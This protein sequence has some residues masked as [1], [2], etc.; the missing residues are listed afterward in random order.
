MGSSLVA[1]ALLSLLALPACASAASGEVVLALPRPLKAGEAA[2][3]VVEVG[4]LQRGHEIVVTTSSGQLI[5]TISPF[6]IRPGQAAGSYALPVPA[7][8][9]KDGKLS[10]RLR[11]TGTGGPPRAPTAQEVKSLKLSITPAPP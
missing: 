11:L 8:A 5:G 3:V 7:E 1:L 2:T 10:L 9:V 4:V 6:G